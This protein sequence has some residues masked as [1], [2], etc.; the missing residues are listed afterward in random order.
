[1][2]E[3]SIDKIM[4]V[5]C[6]YITTTTH[7]TNSSA[8]FNPFGRYLLAA[9]C[10]KGAKRGTT[11]AQGYYTETAG[12]VALG[13]RAD[14]CI[15]RVWG[16]TAFEHWNQIVDFG[17]NVTRFDVQVTIVTCEPPG[18]RMLMVWNENP[19][20]TSGKGRRSK[21]KKVVGPTGIETMYFGNRQSERFLRCYDKWI[22][23]RD[24]YYAGALRWE[25]ELKGEI[26][27]AYA[28]QLSL[29]S[30]PQ[31]D[32][33]ATIAGYVGDRLKVGVSAGHLRTSA[34]DEIMCSRLSR[35]AHACNRT[36]AYLAK[37]VRPT[38][39]RLKSAGL[40]KEVREALGLD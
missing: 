11:R 15:L 2:S 30:S 12:S 24:P 3:Q 33:F 25:L 22:Q 5:G 13:R 14:G 9:E 18:D 40:E 32:M 26:A 17:G 4:E 37:Q 28:S 16:Q 36:L 21:V 31:S 8:S 35:P 34:S 38:I 23:S 19:G 1:M 7:E 10:Q 6:D 39:E 27:L 20:W 29:R